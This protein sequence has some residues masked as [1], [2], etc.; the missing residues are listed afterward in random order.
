ME[1]ILPFNAVSNS[2]KLHIPANEAIK[3]TIRDDLGISTK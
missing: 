3:L 2:I 1:Q